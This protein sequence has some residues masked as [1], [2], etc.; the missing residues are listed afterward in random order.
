MFGLWPS[1]AQV[2]QRITWPSKDQEQGHPQLEEPHPESS[3]FS[4]TAWTW[5]CP[6]LQQGT[7]LISLPPQTRQTAALQG[8]GQEILMGL[9]FS[10]M[11]L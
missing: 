7:E 6:I 2:A 8:R 4:C 3:L 10:L 11:A 5:S 9:V 1:L